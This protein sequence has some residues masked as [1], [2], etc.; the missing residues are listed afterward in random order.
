MNKKIIVL[1]TSFPRSADDDAGVFVSHLVTALA[2]KGCSGSVIA[3][4]DVTQ[5]TL[6]SIKSFTINRFSYGLCTAGRLAFGAGIIPNLKHAPLLAFQ[7]PGFL[8]CF[9]LKTLRLTEHSST[10][11]ANWII[12]GFIAWLVSLIK[13]NR[14]LITIR[15]EDLRLLEK[16]LLKLLFTPA[17]RNAAAVVTVSASLRETFLSYQITTPDKTHVIE[18]GVDYQPVSKEALEAW[19]TQ[20]GIAEDEKYLLFVGTVIPRKNIEKIISILSQPSLQEYTLRICGRLDDRLEYVRLL[21]IVNNMNLR[22]RV[23]FEGPIAPRF[24]S[25]YLS[26]ATAFITTSQ[27]EG[28]PNAVLEALAYGKVVFASD[29]PAHREIIQDQS[30]GFIIDN[31]A[32]QEIADDIKAI[33]TNQNQQQLVSL[34]AKESV[35]QLSWEKTAEKYLAL[36]N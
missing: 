24:I 30:N 13:R 12:S 21:E 15:G 18:N 36:F 34:N 27:F 7:I 35:A 5:E 14:Y 22:R 4:K 2:E 16:P 23:F 6:N 31:R 26:F 17:L 1:S 10:V 20:I 9:F 19:R 33:L 25:H 29:I 28:R 8:I 3:P 11:Q 32:D